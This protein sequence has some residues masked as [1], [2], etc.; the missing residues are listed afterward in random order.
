MATKVPG[1]FYT[2]Y[3]QIQFAGPN[4]LINENQYMKL[5]QVARDSSEAIN[6]RYE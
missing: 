1:F 4:L 6:E 3:R 5:L 2:S